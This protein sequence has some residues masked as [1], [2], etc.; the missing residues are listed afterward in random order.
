MW[1]D[2][3]QSLP[4]I[5]EARLKLSKQSTQP[6]VDATTHQSI[7]ESFRYSVNTRPNFAF[8]IGYMSRFLE[9]PQEDHLAR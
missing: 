2:K 6:L 3:M 8:V 4:N 1:L 7:I 9:E 5:H